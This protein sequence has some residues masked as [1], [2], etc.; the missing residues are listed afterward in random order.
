LL[1]SAAYFSAGLAENPLLQIQELDVIGLPAAAVAVP[2][3]FPPEEAEED[4]PDQDSTASSI[5]IN[6][7]EVVP[8]LPVAPVLVAPLMED[9]HLLGPE[10]AEVD[11]DA[12]AALVALTLPPNQPIHNNT[13][14]CEL[15][16]D[17]WIC[18]F[19]AFLNL[20]E[21]VTCALCEV[22]RGTQVPE[23]M[24]VPQARWECLLCT[25]AENHWDS[26]HCAAC[27][28][29]RGLE[30]L[31]E[32]VSADMRQGDRDGEEAKGEEMK[33]EVQGQAEP[34][35]VE[36]NLAPVIVAAPAPAQQ[37]K[38]SIPVSIAATL[39]GDLEPMECSICCDSFCAG[40]MYRAVSCCSVCQSC[41]VSWLETQI[42]G[43]DS[44]ELR[45]NC[46]SSRLLYSHLS[47]LI[48]KLS[49]ATRQRYQQARRKE[50][51]KEY[52]Q[53]SCPECEQENWVPPRHNNIQC[54]NPHCHSSGALICVKHT[55]RHSRPDRDL[56]KPRRCAACVEE[57]G[58]DGLLAS[59]LSEIQEA[60]CDR[61]PSCNGYV[62]GP[63]SFDSCLCLKCNHCPRAFCG[64]CYEYAGN[65]SD[66][67]AHVRQCARN[68]RVNYFVESEAV[69]NQLMRQR[70]ME[71]GER[72]ISVSPLSENSKDEARGR[73]LLL[74]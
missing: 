8:P 50:T 17:S 14:P 3:R 32:V 35:V 71:I 55:L 41:M 1:T 59:V 42:D 67:H 30:A 33:E 34:R 73:M 72:I 27:G 51:L 63:E 48:D 39:E 26:S 37:A 64:F 23:P 22:G 74:L 4:V 31:G 16:G 52:L 25:L 36:D 21:A 53:F 20:P 70:R 6:A 18:S 54:S 29:P 9:L 61:C 7:R 62:G 15:V 57:C 68:P 19:C 40:E 5:P 47:T 28:N 24:A 38:V 66:T 69:W 49:R 11:D 58:G 56:S 43:G 10:V 65:W 2:T 45:C 44:L 12:R 13:P 60:F 46:R